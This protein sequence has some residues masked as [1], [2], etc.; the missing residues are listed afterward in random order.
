[1]RTGGPFCRVEFVCERDF[2]GETG[3]LI[4]RGSRRSLTLLLEEGTA[5]IIVGC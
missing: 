2:R 1:M 4:Q 3:E 5:I